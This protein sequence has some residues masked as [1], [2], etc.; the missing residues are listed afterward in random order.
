[1]SKLSELDLD[2]LDSALLDA[3]E[4][5]RQQDDNQEA[6][7]RK[8]AYKKLYSRLFMSDLKGEQ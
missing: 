3:I 1:M 8:E 2:L 4:F 7:D 5:M 6:Q